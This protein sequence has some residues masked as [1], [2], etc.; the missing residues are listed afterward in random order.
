M[1]L[2]KKTDET[3]S[4]ALATQPEYLSQAFINRAID[5]WRTRLFYGEMDGR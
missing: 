2:L 3:C 1:A 5:Q 4:T